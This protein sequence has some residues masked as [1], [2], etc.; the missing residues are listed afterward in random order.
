MKTRD[1][2][3]LERDPKENIESRVILYFRRH[4]KKEKTLE[5]QADEQVPLTKEGRA[6]AVAVGKEL[7]AHPEVAVAFGS[8]RDRAQE[9]AARAMLANEESITEDMTLDELKT[10]IRG[11]LGYGQ[12]IMADSRLN[13][14]DEPGELKE[15]TDKAYGE[16]RTT[17]FMVH[18]S[19]EVAKRTKDKKSSSYTRLAGQVAELVKKYAEIGNNFHRIV[20]EDPEKYAEFQNRL[21][22]FMGTH[23]TVSES[24]V[25]KVLEKQEGVEERERFLEKLGAFGFAEAQGFN[26]E[27]VNRSDAQEI[28]LTVKAGDQEWNLVIKPEVLDEIINDR[29][30]FDQEILNG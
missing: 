1:A 14:V 17:D 9:I 19:D 24:F 20:E 7:G 8:S 27:V 15:L 25:A 3:R 11:E 28:K 12:K 2:S 22:R 23:N 10:E 21:E 4:G 26:L 18:E 30:I 6:Q 29:E 13:F 16:K 5:G